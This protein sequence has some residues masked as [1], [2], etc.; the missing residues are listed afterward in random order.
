[1]WARRRAS[2]MSAS[3]S[4]ARSCSPLFDEIS[5]LMRLRGQLEEGSSILC[6]PPCRCRQA[7]TRKVLLYTQHGEQQADKREQSMEQLVENS[8]AVWPSLLQTA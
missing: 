6:L 5:M 3:F 2:L 7:P 1:M 8:L 4:H